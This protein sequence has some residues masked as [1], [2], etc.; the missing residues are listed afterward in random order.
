MDPTDRWSCGK[1]PGRRFIGPRSGTDRAR[2]GQTPGAGRRAPV[3]RRLLIES[4]GTGATGELL[5][6]G[7]CLPQHAGDQHSAACAQMS[8]DATG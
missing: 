4:R 6:G 8:S 2:R 5:G 7:M 3:D 1:H